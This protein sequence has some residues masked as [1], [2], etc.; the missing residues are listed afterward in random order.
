MPLRYK[1][2]FTWE[3]WL[4]RLCRLVLDGAEDVQTDLQNQPEGYVRCSRSGKGQRGVGLYAKHFFFSHPAIKVM[5]RCD[6][7]VNYQN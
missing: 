4:V 5:N 2:L 1:A 3:H 6:G 7:N